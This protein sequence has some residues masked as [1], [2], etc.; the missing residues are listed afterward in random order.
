MALDI[1]KKRNDL[2]HPCLHVIHFLFGP[3]HFL[4]TERL[5]ALVSHRPPHLL[6]QPPPFLSYRFLSSPAQPNHLTWTDFTGKLTE[7]IEIS[8]INGNILHL[9]LYQGL[10]S[11]LLINAWKRWKKGNRW[12]KRETIIPNGHIVKGKE[13]VECRCSCQCLNS[14]NCTVISKG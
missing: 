10:Q 9:H 14:G 1:R 6:C 8:A 7:R 12:G 4:Q 5:L 3:Q 2:C 11:L 13:K